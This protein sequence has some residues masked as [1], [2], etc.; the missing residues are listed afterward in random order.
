MYLDNFLLVLLSILNIIH[1]ANFFTY[2][3]FFLFPINKICMHVLFYYHFIFNSLKHNFKCIFVP[4]G[5]V[6][7]THFNQYCDSIYWTSHST[8]N[9]EKT[10]QLMRNS[11]FPSTEKQNSY[12]TYIP[13][14]IE[15][16][17]IYLKLLLILSS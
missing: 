9:C 12:T 11:Y 1:Q 5:P 13:V 8:Y 6:N 10:S 3:Q 15:F 17:I 7:H 16:Y 4:I 2:A 14:Y